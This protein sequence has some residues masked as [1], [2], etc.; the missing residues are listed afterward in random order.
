MRVHHACF[1]TL[2]MLISCRN[3]VDN[4]TESPQL[5]ENT[6]TN[7]LIGKWRGT[8]QDGLGAFVMLGENGKAVFYDGEVTY[9]STENKITITEQG[10]TLVLNY[11]LNGDHLELSNTENDIKLSLQRDASPTVAPGNTPPEN[12]N[13]EGGSNGYIGT[14]TGKSGRLVIR[15]NGTLQLG[16]AEMNYRLEG[17]VMHLENKT[18][19]SD[20]ELN[21]EGNQLSVT[22]VNGSG[23]R[24]TEVFSKGESNK[25]AGGTT[26]IAGSWMQMSTTSTNSGAISYQNVLT[27]NPDGTFQYGSEGSMD[28][29]GSS[30]AGGVSHA[31]SNSGTWNYDGTNLYLN[32]N[33]MRCEK[34][35]YKND[36]ALI[37]NGTYYATR[38]QRAGW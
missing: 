5:Q 35:Y 33:A 27:L 21:L 11:A 25:E 23:Q 9:T 19:K 14:W 22:G 38:I 4:K 32:G 12:G 7:P 15:E 13:T 29:S 36:P 28:Y 34:G 18:N 6:P 20:V 17:N 31:A 30:S 24:V 1:L 10:Q 8:D 3:S 16:G 26:E 2:L 37:I